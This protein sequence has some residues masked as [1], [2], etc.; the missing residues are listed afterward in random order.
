MAVG[1]E[2]K[3]QDPP[4]VGY[5][6]SDFPEGVENDIITLGYNGAAFDQSFSNQL[7]LPVITNRH[8]PGNILLMRCEQGL[9][10]SVDGETIGQS[11]IR[12]VAIC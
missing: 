6:L 7:F 12:A 3:G 4:A 11:L 5:T 2:G 8:R 9:F 1:G 10:R